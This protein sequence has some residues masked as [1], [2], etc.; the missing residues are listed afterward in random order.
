MSNKLHYYEMMAL[1]KRQDLESGEFMIVKTTNPDRSSYLPLALQVYE[2]DWLTDLDAQP[3]SKQNEIDQGIEYNKTTGRVVAYHMT[4]PD[5]WGK[6]IRIK[7]KN[8]IHGFETLRPGQL[9]GISPFVPAVL[10]A[11]ELGEYMDAEMDGAK[12]AAKYMAFVKSPDMYARQYGRVETDTDTDQQIEEMENAII[13][14]LQPGEEI[15]IATNPRP[16]SNFPPFVRLILTMISVSTGVPYELLSGDY[17][18]MN[19][20]TSRTVRNDFSQQ[21]RPIV[22]RHVRHFGAPTFEW[23]M[24]SAVMSNRLNLPNYFT[25]PAPWLRSEWQPPGM[26]SIDPLRETKARVDEIKTGLRSPQEV[27]KARGRDLEDVYDEIST[28]KAMAEERGLNF[29]DVSTTVHNNPA[30]ITGG[31]E[32]E[33]EEKE[34]SRK[35]K[36]SHLALAH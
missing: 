15:E 28:A 29:Q 13:E 24:E 3:T 12:M 36:L 22:T 31:D 14:Y 7:A 6:S 35:A 33:K 34:R 17:Q 26:E 4:D 9:R 5:G 32:D 23:F 16:G 11:H 25:N 8:V 20:S 18:G 10:V 2:T 21:I 19:Y 1:M 27:V 30:E